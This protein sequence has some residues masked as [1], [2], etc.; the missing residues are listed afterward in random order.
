MVDFDLEIKNA[1]SINIKEIELSQYIIDDNIKK[2]IILYNTA[3]GEV[4]KGN[5]DLVINDLKKALSYNEG[6]TE[7][8]KLMGLCYVNMKEYKKAEKTFKKLNKD[9]MYNELANEYMQ[10]LSIKKSMDECI[11]VTEIVKNVSNNKKKQYNLAIYSK[12]NIVISLVIFMV[13]IAGVSINY[14]YQETIQ[15][16]FTKF[17]TSIQGEQKNNKMHDSNEETYI[18]SDED[19]VL[20][21]EN[22]VSNG[23]YKNM[24]NN[25]A[26][27]KLDSDNYK[28]N[29]V[30][31]LKDAEEFLNNGNYE[32]AAS[33]LISMK[34]N[35]FDDETK[36]KFD[37]LWQ[38]LKPNSLW[39]I[40]NDGNKLYKQKKYLEA[41]PKLIIASEIDPKL[42]LMPWITFQ[43][44]MCYKETNDNDNALIY[45]NKVKDNYPKSQYASNARMMISQIGN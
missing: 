31:M 19:E 42:D 20:M 33:I 1:R 34:S 35:S 32:K 37:K 29:I 12:R 39:I 13:V 30:S 11:T 38:S 2:S 3:I 7:A 36:M 18:N 25:L 6:F 15:G 10:S 26:D 28:N 44:G 21:Q 41:L 43:I 23:E 9:I 14:F 5:F 24:Q 27:T 40:Y 17:N 16:V 45:F 8:I 22:T 4:K